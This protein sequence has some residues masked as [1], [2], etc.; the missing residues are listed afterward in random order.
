MPYAIQGTGP[1]NW[2]LA[3][4]GTPMWHTTWYNFAPRLG[5]TYFLRNTP[6]SETVIR[7]GVGVFFDTGQTLVSLGFDNPGFSTRSFNPGSFSVKATGIIP[8]FANHPIPP[9]TSTTSLLP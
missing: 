3:R 1:D 4:Q 7:G 9:P 2:T 5:A 6:D 8:P